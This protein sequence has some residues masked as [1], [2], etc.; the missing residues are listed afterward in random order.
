MCRWCEGSVGSL[1]GFGVE[2]RYAMRLGG[3][4]WNGSHFDVVAG[5]LT[6]ALGALRDRVVEEQAFSAGPIVVVTLAGSGDEVRCF[7]GAEL[8]PEDAAPAGLEA[9]DLPSADY[10]TCWHK[11]ADGSVIDR[12]GDMLDWMRLH[13]VARDKAR[14]L[15]REEYPLHAD[16]GRPEGLRLMVPVVGSRQ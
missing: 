2:N 6:G 7:L 14:W 12:Y 9:F 5:G 8:G 11:M 15:H 3:R 1:E 16:F 10:A 4:F 13:K